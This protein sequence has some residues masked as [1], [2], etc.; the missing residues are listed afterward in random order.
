[1]LSLLVVTGLSTTRR[2]CLQ[3][4]THENGKLIREIF[5]ETIAGIDGIVMTSVDPTNGTSSP[6]H[7]RTKRSPCSQRRFHHDDLRVPLFYGN[8]EIVLQILN[9]LIGG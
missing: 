3:C 6:A 5:L 7:E 1:M 2:F 8:V 4:L 9:N